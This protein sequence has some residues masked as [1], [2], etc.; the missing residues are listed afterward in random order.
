MVYE[1]SKLNET[2]GTNYSHNLFI[3]LLLEYG[4][5]IFILFT[6]MLLT[7]V[8]RMYKSSSLVLNRISYFMIFCFPVLTIVDEGYQKNHIWLFLTSIYIIYYC[9]KHRIDVKLENS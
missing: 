5:I 8:Y 7:M 6:A 2:L 9:L 1:L 4:L 3:Q